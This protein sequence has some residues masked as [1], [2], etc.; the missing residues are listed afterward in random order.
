M[1]T[2]IGVIGDIH[3]ETERLRNALMFLQEMNLDTILCTGDVVD[4]TGDVDE[5]CDLLREHHVVIVKGNHDEWFLKNTMRNLPVATPVHAVNE[6][7]RRFLQDLPLELEFHTPAGNLLL[8][9]G[10]GKH[11][12]A[13][14]R[15]DD[16]GYALE[17][18]FELQELIQSRRY[19]FILNGH[20]HYRMM[21]NFDGLT[22]INAGSLLYEDAGFQTIDF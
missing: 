22:V 6:V 16:Y 2:N 17:S 14:V 21:R 9:H 15:D 3:A 4:G 8:C 7:S 10:L 19:Q 11:T 5:C 20:T 13:K 12:M 18:N 1:L